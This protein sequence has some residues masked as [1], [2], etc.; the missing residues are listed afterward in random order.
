MEDWNGCE[1]SGIALRAAG[2]APGVVGIATKGREIDPRE[3]GMPRGDED[4][5]EGSGDAEQGAGML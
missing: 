5:P 4:R 2:I 1:M 3:A